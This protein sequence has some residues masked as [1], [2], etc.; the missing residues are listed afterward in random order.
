MG[1]MTAVEA[2]AGAVYGG[3]SAYSDG[4][5]TRS[6]VL[7]QEMLTDLMRYG[8]EIVELPELILATGTMPVWV[9][10]RHDVW[11]TRSHKV[12]VENE[13]GFHGIFDPNVARELA[14]A[15]LAAANLADQKKVTL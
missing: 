8:A 1:T 9:G 2:L 12:G 7:A 13:Q 3:A 6:G 14:A 11:I 4:S 5:P 10:H 15:L